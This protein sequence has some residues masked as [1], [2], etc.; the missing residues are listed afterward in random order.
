VSELLKYVAELTHEEQAK[1]ASIIRAKLIAEG[2][3][4]T[5]EIEESIKN[6]L[7]SKYSDIAYMI[8]N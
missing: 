4:T 3:Y 2:I 8:E 6:A 5:D 7:D 1:I